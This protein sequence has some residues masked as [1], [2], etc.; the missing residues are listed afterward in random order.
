MSQFKQKILK[1]SKNCIRSVW[2]KVCAD[3]NLE[4][5]PKKGS[6]AGRQRKR[7]DGDLVFIQSV[8]EEKQST[9]CSEIADKL[10]HSTVSIKFTFKR[11]T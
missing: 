11:I 8:L 4:L 6:G 3:G 10:E 9:S 2:F 7:S 5:Q 1:V